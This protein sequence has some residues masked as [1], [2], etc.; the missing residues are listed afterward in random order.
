MK[1]QL[2][3]KMHSPDLTAYSFTIDDWSTTSA[4]ESLLSSTVHWVQDNFVHAS[5]VLHVANLEGSYS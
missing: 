4:G 1:A 2:V 5:A 3:E